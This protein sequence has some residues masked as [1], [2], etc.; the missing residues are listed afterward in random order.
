[1]KIPWFGKSRKAAQ[2][3]KR[4]NNGRSFE[5]VQINRLTKDFSEMNASINA[6]IRAGGDRLRKLARQMYENSSHARRWVDLYVINVIGEN[7]HILQSDIKIPEE[8]PTTNEVIEVSDDVKNNL[9]ETAWAEW[10]K[11]E[12]CS[13]TQIQSFATMQKIW[14]RHK[15]RDGEIFIR[16]VIDPSSKYGLRLQTIPPELIPESY[17]EILPNGNTILCGIEFNEWRK[18]VAYYVSKN[19]VAQDMWG[20]TSIAGDLERIPASEM[21]HWFD[22]DFSNQSRGYTRMANVILML[23]WLKDY[24]RAS[25]LNAKFS[26]RKLGFLRD[27]TPEDPSETFSSD[28]ESSETTESADG[29]TQSTQNRPAVSGEELTFTYIGNTQ[30][31]KWDPQYPHP[32]HEM[33]NRVAL[34]DIA[35]GLNVA[36]CSLAGD[37]SNSTWS[38]ARTELDVERNNWLHEQ[39]IMIDTVDTKIFTWWLELALLKRAIGTFTFRD[40]DRLNKPY[41]YGPRWEYINP[42]DESNALRSDL[43]AQFISPFDVAAKKGKR[44]ED[45]YRDINAAAKLRKKF[46]ITEPTYGATANKATGM[47]PSQTKPAAEPAAQEQQNGVT[48]NA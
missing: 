46:N 14:A 18:P 4:T 47:E 13:V 34:R 5:A 45:V 3:T 38:S 8:D 33:F 30:L 40:Y 32:Q 27:I 16:R 39:Q 6:D 19:K 42:V 37:Y 15:S 9:I 24:N 10:S 26:A 35:I 22:P 44:L 48:A 25:V 12:Q 2:Q 21:I 1:M 43:E 23:T 11:A 31:E 41:F 20:V 7:G 36:Y 17:N 29:Q 28:K